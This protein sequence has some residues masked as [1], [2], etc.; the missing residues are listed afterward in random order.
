M[1]IVRKG[2]I[3][4]GC[5]NKTKALSSDQKLLILVQSDNMHLI[6]I[7]QGYC[8]F[9]GCNMKTLP[10]S[11]NADI[12]FKALKTESPS[13]VFIDMEQAA[14]IFN[15]PEWPATWLLMQQ[16]K[17]ALCGI[18]KQLTNYS[19]TVPQPVFNKIF[20]DPLNI[21]EIES[22]LDDRMAANIVNFERRAK[23]RRRGDRRN[24]L[25]FIENDASSVSTPR[26]PYI[27]YTPENKPDL[28]HSRRIGQLVIDYLAKSISVNGIPIEISPK[29]FQFIDF[30]AQQ[31]GSCG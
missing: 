1:N 5:F 30:L 12:F 31:P 6:G 23:E 21:D 24:K 22:F 13:M 28:G 15:A 9:A 10:C 8:H 18:G 19:E 25:V 4:D 26:H 2:E 11:N 27:E 20:T 3:V 14:Q 29:E 7:F 17:I 16:N